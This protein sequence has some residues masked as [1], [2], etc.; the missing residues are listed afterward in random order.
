M[1]AHIE[2]VQT[3]SEFGGTHWDL[4][5]RLAFRFCLAYFGL[6]CL[7]TQI[8]VGL[9]P[10]PIPNVDDLDPA[11]WW[12]IKQTVFWVAA[13]IFR[14]PLPLVY[15]GS[16][17]GDKT[18]DWV[19]TFCVLILAIAATGLWSVLD[20]KRA[21]YTALYKWFRLFIRFALAS[22]MILYG[23]S[24]AIPLQMPFPNLTRLLEPFGN[25]S[26]MGVLWYSVGA[27]PAYEIFA[28]CAEILAGILLIVPR[29]TTLGALICLVDM[30]QVFMLNMTYDV[31]VKLFSFHLILMAMFLIAPEFSGLADFFLRNRAAGPSSEPDLFSTRRANRIALAAQILFGACLVGANAY[32][33][34]GAWHTFGGGRPRSP[35]YGIWDVDQ[36]S[37]DGQIRSPLLTDYDRWR[38]AIFDFPTTVSFQRMDNSVAGYGATFNVNDKTIA[39]TKNGDKNWKANFRFHQVAPNRMIL[40]GTMG[41]HGVHMELQQVEVNKF[42]L[43]SRGFHWIQEYPFNR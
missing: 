4:R 37:I 3:K 19:L 9:F 29:T 5:R 41:G 10:V 39:L 6:Y 42:M 11:A 23:M 20:R 40:D 8:I 16:G 15:S 32:S 22:E 14:A 18:F 1:A 33:G 43:V 21:N 30:I 25:F 36:M 38:R 12:P 2:P 24:K 31:P 35:L 28:G 17:S 27:S 13:H 26:P 7:T 34:W